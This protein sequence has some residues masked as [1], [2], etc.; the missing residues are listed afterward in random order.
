MRL[1]FEKCPSARGIVSGAASGMI[2]HVKEVVENGIH[3][4]SESLKRLAMERLKALGGDILEDVIAGTTHGPFSHV[5][6]ETDLPPTGL[7]RHFSARFG[8]GVG[9][10]DIANAD[11]PKRWAVVSVP[12]CDNH[13]AAGW[14]WEL[15]G[16]PYD[17]LGAL[18]CGFDMPLD[19]PNA[20]FCS[21]VVTQYLSRC[22]A[23]DLPGFC[24]P[25]GLY[26]CLQSIGIVTATA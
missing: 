19:N 2:A 22:G 24:S 3:A 1:L 8:T 25:N 18:S 20:R 15:C 6:L 16:T 10:V 7:G 12:W 4:A 9:Y 17:F 23:L 13:I 11:D 21:Q 26:R 14:A 5:E